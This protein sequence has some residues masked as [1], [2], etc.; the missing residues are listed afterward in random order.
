MGKVFLKSFLSLFVAIDAVGALPLLASLTKGMSLAGRQRLVNKSS[1]AAL[2]I[3]LAFVFMGQAIFDF[4]GITENDFRVAGG[5]LLLVF[6]IKDLSSSTS[7]QGAETPSSVGIVPIAIPLMMGPAAVTTLMIGS[8]EFGT[9]LTIVALVLNLLV[10]W[11]LFGRAS[12]LMQKI[13]AEASEAIAKISSLFL[14]AIAVM[15]IRLGI[16]GMNF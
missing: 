12:W 14:A 7:H 16:V 11:V 4:L 6:A 15:L 3:G 1:L 9:L 10:A 2:G 5:V 13:G 8:K